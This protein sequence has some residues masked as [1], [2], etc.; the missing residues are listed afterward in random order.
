M[1]IRGRSPGESAS[2]VTYTH[3]SCQPK[4]AGKPCPP[5]SGFLAGVIHGI[6][7]HCGRRSQLCERVLR[8]SGA[9]CG[10][11]DRQIPL[12]WM[13]FV[14]LRNEHGR[15]TCIILRRNHFDVAD[16]LTPGDRVQ[17]GRD[18][19]RGQGVWILPR[20]TGPTWYH[21]WPDRKPED[22]MVP[23]L[24]QY[25]RVPHLAVD[26]ARWFGFECHPGVT[27]QPA[28]E[29]IGLPVPTGQHATVNEEF[30]RRVR[31]GK[32]PLNGKNG[33]H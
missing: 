10:G 20:T 14:P 30:V 1:N 3:D 31:S 9:P 22:N 25:L 32:P 29:E 13:G 4:E 6:E 24:V 27:D 23:W 11:C 15:P 33:K 2:H 21:F 18:E 7:A 16:K 28:T 8:G 12:D 5:R 26:L 17:W 19:G